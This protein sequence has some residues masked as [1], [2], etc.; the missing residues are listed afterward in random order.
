LSA[1]SPCSKSVRVN[2]TGIDWVICGGETVK[3]GQRNDDSSELNKML[4]GVVCDH[5][6]APLKVTPH[7]AGR[8]LLTD[9]FRCATCRR[10]NLLAFSWAF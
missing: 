4:S 2:L 5:C 10:K 8:I 6:K 1:S 3:S 9:S 7:N